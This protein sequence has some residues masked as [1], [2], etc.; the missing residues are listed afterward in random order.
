MPTIAT[1][2]ATARTGKNQLQWSWNSEAEES[3]WAMW[4]E[5]SMGAGA[6][7]EESSKADLVWREVAADAGEDDTDRVSEEEDCESAAGSVAGGKAVNDVEVW[8]LT[9]GRHAES[10]PHTLCKNVGKDF[11]TPELSMTTGRPWTR[12]IGT[13]QRHNASSEPAEVPTF[14]TKSRAI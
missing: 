13:S 10:K 6:Q 14:P 4:Q 8:W 2:A 9:S 7:T 1:T 5:E 11:Q 3:S 12:R